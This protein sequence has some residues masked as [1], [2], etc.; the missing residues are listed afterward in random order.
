VLKADISPDYLDFL[1]FIEKANFKV[2]YSDHLFKT[3]EM[4]GRKI[5]FGK[6]TGENSYYIPVYF[7]MNYTPELI[8]GTFAEVYL[9]GKELQDAIVIPNSS[10]LEEYGKLYVFVED[11][12]GDFLKRYVTTGISDGEYTRILDGLEGNET[13]VVKGTYQIKLSQMS[14]S[15]PAHNH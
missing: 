9:I 7:R 8:E 3:D 6:S 1:P 14:T 5:S 15:A 4:N 13:I 11:D 10:L 2:G 12:D